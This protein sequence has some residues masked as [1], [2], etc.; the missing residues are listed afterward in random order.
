M[1]VMFT[2]GSIL[3]C[4]SLR[5]KPLNKVEIDGIVIDKSLIAMVWDFSNGKKGW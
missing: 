1:T 4:E 2:D 5:L 3:E